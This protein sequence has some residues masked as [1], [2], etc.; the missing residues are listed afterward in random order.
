[1]RLFVGIELD[2]GVRAAALDAAAALRMSDAPLRFEKPEK[3]H[4]TLAFLGKTSPE[5]LD[6]VIEA[7][8]H[9]AAQ[10]APFTLTFDR[11]GAFP[12]ERRPRVIWL[13]ARE[14]QPSFDICARAVRTAMTTLGWTFENEAVAHVTLCRAKPP[15]RGM[16]PA[17]DVEQASE[18]NVT[19]LTLFESLPAGPT[20]RYEIRERFLLGR[21]ETKTK[22]V[23]L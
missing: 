20:T 9:A 16:P 6:L 19:H 12:N 13:G 5:Q 22:R 1:M 2:D 15:L 7:L 3:M 18:L 23:A 21:R 10:V 4:V 11:I 8:A 14:S 17:P